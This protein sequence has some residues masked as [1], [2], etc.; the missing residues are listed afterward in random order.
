[1]NKYSPENLPWRVKKDEQAAL[2]PWQVVGPS[3]LVSASNDRRNAQREVKRLN[4]AF[5]LG[6]DC[7][8]AMKPS[9]GDG[10]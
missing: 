9:A 6:W 10:E 7:H 8:A 1:M 4:D 2:C 5:L 3:G